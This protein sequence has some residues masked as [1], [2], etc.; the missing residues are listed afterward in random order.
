M[1]S[2]DFDSDD[3]AKAMSASHEFVSVSSR[4]F[5][6]CGVGMTRGKGSGARCACRVI[7]IVTGL[8]LAC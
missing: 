3:L 7:L 8:G 1:T 2:K 4:Y 6:H 5:Y